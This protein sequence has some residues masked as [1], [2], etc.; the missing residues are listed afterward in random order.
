MQP[1]RR[2]GQRG[3][4]VTQTP[5]SRVAS[6]STAAIPKAKTS[7]PRDGVNTIIH[8]VLDLINLYALRGFN[9]IFNSLIFTVLNK[10]SFYNHLFAHAGQ[11]LKCAI[12]YSC[13]MLDY[14]QG[15][16]CI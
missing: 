7:V 6:H 5:G 10:S 4:D 12:R 14:T 1:L 11:N 9:F 16:S 15:L 3:A 8:S 13:S 2:V